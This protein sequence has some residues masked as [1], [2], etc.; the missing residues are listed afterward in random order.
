MTRVPASPSRT[1]RT[2]NERGSA[3]VEAVIVVPAFLLL[4][5]LLILGGRTAITQQAVQAAAADAARAASIART[6]SVARSAASSAA[7]GSLTNQNLD[8]VTTTVTVDVAAFG[9]P[10][11]TPGQVTA[12]VT[13]GLR[14]DDLGLPGVTG[15]KTITAT[16][17]SPLDTYRG[18]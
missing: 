15:T 5:G 14:L 3:S 1:R 13:C 9:T 6:A 18:R 12:T 2:Q 8:C 11:G 17:S 16:M 4:I 7:H 10:V